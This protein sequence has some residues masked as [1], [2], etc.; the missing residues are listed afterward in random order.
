M[1]FH[2]SLH[3]TVYGCSGCTPKNSGGIIHIDYS[4]NSRIMQGMSCTE[5]HSSLGPLRA[6]LS[7]STAQYHTFLS[8][9]IPFNHIIL[10]CETGHQVRMNT[11][12]VCFCFP[13]QVSLQASC[14]AG[15]RD[16][17][18]LTTLERTSMCGFFSDTHVQVAEKYF[19]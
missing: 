2:S 13:S 12:K 6:T 17:E 14:F 18:T 19:Q 3:V 5:A 4:V 9:K 11:E 1:G 16:T 8:L 10:V 15:I 7:Q